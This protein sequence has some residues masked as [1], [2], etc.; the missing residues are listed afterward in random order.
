[1]PK[2]QIGSD[3]SR[4]YR[5]RGSDAYTIQ[6]NGVKKLIYQAAW[7]ENGEVAGPVEISMVIPEDMTH[8]IR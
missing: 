7:R 5:H 6:K 2:R 8:Y 4:T 3:N 1:M